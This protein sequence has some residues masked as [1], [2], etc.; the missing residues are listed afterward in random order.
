M[1]AIK[2]LHDVMEQ[3]GEHIPYGLRARIE[4][5]LKTGGWTVVAERL[6]DAYMPVIAV[7]NNRALLA[8]FRKE[9][10]SPSGWC[11]IEAMGL[12]DKPNRG[13][14]HWQPLPPLPEAKHG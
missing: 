6:P 8:T 10:D 11:H 7:V 5:L 12:F 4:A 1:S 13:V 9:N 14:T 3:A 2:L